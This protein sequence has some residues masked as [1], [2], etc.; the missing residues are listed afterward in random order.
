MYGADD[1]APHCLITLKQHCITVSEKGNRLIFQHPNFR[2]TGK[3]KL[4]KFQFIKVEL[5]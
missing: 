3:L 4:G 5:T 1:Y 2:V